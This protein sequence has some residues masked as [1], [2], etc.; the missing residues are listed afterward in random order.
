MSIAPEI[1]YQLHL[2]RFVAIDIETTGLD[3]HHS[4][5][6]EVG[7]V[8]FVDG[9]PAETFNQL[10][11]PARAIPEEITRIT[12]ISNSMVESCNAWKDT[13]EQFLTF[14]GEDPIV[15]HNINFDIPFLEYHCRRL[16]QPFFTDEIIKSFLIFNNN[17]H[18]TLLLAKIYLP[19]LTSFSLKSL[20]AYFDIHPESS[21]R[22]LPDAETAGEIFLRLV[23]HSLTT[24]FR[25][26]RQILE[27]LDPTDEPLKTFFFHL[28]QMLASGKYHF[29]VQF[30]RSTF[31]YTA[32]YYNILGEEDTPESGRLQVE[33]IDENEMADFFAEGGTLQKEFKTFESRVSQMEMARQTANAFNNDQ[34]LVA[35][36]GTGTGKSMAYLLPAIKWS[37]RNYGPFGRV[38]IST[39][40][41]NL[42]EQLFFKDLPILYSVLKDKFKTVLLKGK[43]NYLC[44]D[45][46]HTILS[47]MRFRLSSYERVKM[48]PL[49]M[50]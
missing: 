17:L 39:N 5:I 24:E 6:I 16:R 38:V 1:L 49:Y 13:M 21:H 47:D 15:A 29:P 43:G 48:L 37:I 44:L 35:E 20:A 30:D 25:E 27:I 2:T 45:K 31:V 41:K 8:R 3:Y 23:E 50:W 26:V 11:R 42:Q 12:G 34:F 32:D 19:F 14:V 46:W 7:A 10:I 36:A 4:E 22:A 28:Q 33:P 9:E 18:D 40:T